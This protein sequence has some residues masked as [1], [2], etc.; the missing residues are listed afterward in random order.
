MVTRRRSR[1]APATIG[2]APPPNAVAE[3]PSA[4]AQGYV[5][6]VAELKPAHHRHPASRGSLG[7]P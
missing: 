2:D 1:E 4:D 6:L 5:A 7:Q 3:A